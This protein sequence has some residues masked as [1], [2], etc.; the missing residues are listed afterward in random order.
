MTM[1]DTARRPVSVSHLFFPLPDP[2]RIAKSEARLTALERKAL[3]PRL[4]GNTA[5]EQGR[6]RLLSVL[7]AVCDG[8]TSGATIS[9]HIDLTVRRTMDYAN[10]A[11]DAELLTKTAMHKIGGGKT[12]RFV[13]TEKGRAVLAAEKGA[14]A[15]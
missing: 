13:L 9:A 15:E 4:I 2:D 5:K 11:H 14:K 7:E 1:Q 8:F 3:T 6:N 10:E 12:Y